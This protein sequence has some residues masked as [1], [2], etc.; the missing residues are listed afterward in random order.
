MK[1]LAINFLKIFFLSLFFPFSSLAQTDPCENGRYIDNVFTS[2]ISTLDIKYGENVSVGGNT[3][4]LFADVFEP[5]NDSEPKRPLM[6]LMHGGS[7]TTGERSDIHNLCEAYA[8]KGYVVASINYRLYDGP[9]F[10]F[11]DSTDLG[12][13]LV[14]S[15]GDAKAAVRFFKNDAATA[16]EFGIDTNIIIMGGV[17]AGAITALHVA[18]MDENDDFPNFIDVILSNNGGLEGN[19]NNLFQHSSKVHGVINFSGALYRDHFLDANETPVFSVH[20]DMDAIVP[21]GN[22]FAVVAIIPIVRMNG[23]ELVHARALNEGVESRL[24]TYENSAGHVSFFPDD[25]QELVDTTASFMA[26]QLICNT[27]TSSKELRSEASHKIYPNPGQNL[28]YIE[29]SAAIARVQVRSITGKVV[30]VLYNG[31]N[32]DISVLDNGVYLIEL[33]DQNDQRINIQKLIKQ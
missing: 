7:Y 8:L 2:T 33:Y 17:S 6:I 16:N 20:D 19:S 23:S 14:Q 31:E 1:N 27:P 3:V 10:P 18:H 13:V 25:R 4:E 28:L 9:F 26:H 11:P 12:E 30:P 5:E 29:N 21:Y 24:I 22:G 32:L 15:V